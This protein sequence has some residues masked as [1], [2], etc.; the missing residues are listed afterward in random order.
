M[1]CSLYD[2][3]SAN[4]DIKAA[5]AQNITVRGIRDYGDEGVVEFIIAQLIYLYKGLGEYQWGNDPTE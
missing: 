5:Q 3:S 4:V 1:C 2:V